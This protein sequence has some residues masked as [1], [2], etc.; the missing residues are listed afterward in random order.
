MACKPDTERKLSIITGKKV[1]PA[2]RGIGLLWDFR[3]SGISYRRFLLDIRRIRGSIMLSI[4]MA[5]KKEAAQHVITPNVEFIRLFIVCFHIVLL[6][7]RN[8]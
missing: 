2:S 5:I 7:I 8:D 1:I 3:L 4:K 6:L